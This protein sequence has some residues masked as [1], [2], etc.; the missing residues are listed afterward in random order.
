MISAT[1]T[2]GLAL[3]FTVVTEL[4]CYK[5]ISMNLSISIFPVTMGTENTALPN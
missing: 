1:R 3:N 4:Q 5:D 2:F